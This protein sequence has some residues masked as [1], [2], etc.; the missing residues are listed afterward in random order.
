MTEYCPQFIARCSSVYIQ[1]FRKLGLAQEITHKTSLSRFDITAS[2][3]EQDRYL[4]NLILLM[5]TAPVP[6]ILQ[7]PYTND[8]RIVVTWDSVLRGCSSLHYNYTQ[9]NSTCGT[10]ELTDDYMV[11]CTNS[12]VNECS[13][14]IQTF[15][16]DV[17]VNESIVTFNIIPESSPAMPTNV[18]TSG[19]LNCNHEESCCNINNTL[20]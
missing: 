4:P 18:T 3:S 9:S 19:T 11:T 7:Q 12:T 8:S 17:L 6:N 1:C 13:L 14:A 16:C 2:C 10:C 5:H 20:Q 15:V